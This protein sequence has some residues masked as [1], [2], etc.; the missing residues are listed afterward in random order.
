[1]GLD[2][3]PFL[4]AGHVRRLSVTSAPDAPLAAV[5]VAVRQ[6]ML[7]EIDQLEFDEPI[8]TLHLADSGTYSALV[9]HTARGRE[10]AHSVPSPYVVGL[11]TP[12][13]ASDV[14]VVQEDAARR[15]LVAWRA[16]YRQF[17]LLSQRS[18]RTDV[19]AEYSP[20]SSYDLAAGRDD[21]FAQ[22]G[23][24]G[25]CVTLFQKGTPM[26]FG[27]HEWEDA[28]DDPAYPQD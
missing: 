6:T 11:A 22:V 21:M 14:H 4:R 10:F 19:L 8:E 27:T 1:M 24:D 13:S 28:P 26:Q 2:D 5:E 16:K 9:V 15:G 23:S 7:S 3:R 20:R 12:T 18:G 25:G 17:T